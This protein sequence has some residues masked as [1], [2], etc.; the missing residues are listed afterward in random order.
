MSGK[1]NGRR[2]NTD[3][4]TVFPG[5]VVMKLVNIDAICNDDLLRCPIPV[6]GRMIIAEGHSPIKDSVDPLTFV[7]LLHISRCALISSL[8]ETGAR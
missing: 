3:E 4:G 2:K 1:R 5:F 8:S 7:G 6:Y